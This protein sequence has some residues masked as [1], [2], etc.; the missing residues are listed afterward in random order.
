MAVNGT[1]VIVRLVDEGTAVSNGP[2]K[3]RVAVPPELLVQGATHMYTLVWL[4]NLKKSPAAK[5]FCVLPQFVSVTEVDPMAAVAD[6]LGTEAVC[7]AR[8]LVLSLGNTISKL[9]CGPRACAK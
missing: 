9:N 6:V 3:N 8:A 5:T 4:L 1:A 7:V 2:E